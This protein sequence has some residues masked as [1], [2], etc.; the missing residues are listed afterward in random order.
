MMMVPED[1]SEDPI[2]EAPVISLQNE[3]VTPKRRG[4]NKPIIIDT[5]PAVHPQ[6]RKGALK[7][8]TSKPASMSQASKP[9]STSQASK[10]MTKPIETPIHI[11][12]TH[13]ERD[14]EEIFADDYEIE[15]IK[16]SPFDHDGA[17]Y[18]REPTK[19]KLFQKQSKGVGDYIGRY[20]PYTGTIR[21]D[22]P[23]S[24]ED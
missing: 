7:P 23:D 1:P 17:S 10:P 11:E 5:E 21:T 15:Y 16:L 9:A 4:K 14:T 8:A 13:I 12:A 22:I 3:I 20:D 6:K 2:P 24:D 19:N 18:L